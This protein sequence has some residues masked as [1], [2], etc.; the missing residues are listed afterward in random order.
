MLL[1]PTSVVGYLVRQ[2]QF[3]AVAPHLGIQMAALQEELAPAGFIW[4]KTFLFDESGSAVPFTRKEARTSQE[5]AVSQ[6]TS[7]SGKVVEDDGLIGTPIG[8]GM[9]GEVRLCELSGYP[10]PVAVKVGLVAGAVALVREAHVLS[11]MSGVRGFPTLHSYQAAGPKASGGTLIL[12]LLGP[13]L[14][15]VCSCSRGQRSLQSESMGQSLQL[16]TISGP[17]VLLVGRA[18]VRLLRPLHRAGFVHNDVK[19]ANILLG[20]GEAQLKRLSSV[21]LIDF[22]SCTR[23]PSHTAPLVS[24]EF[25]GWGASTRGHIGSLRFASV[26]ADARDEDTSMHPADDIESLVYTLAY[27]ATATLPWDGQPDALMTSTKRELLTNGT[28]AAALT[29]GV[30]CERTAAALRELYAEA[31]RCRGSAAG[32]NYQTCVAILEDETSD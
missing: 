22:G 14:K 31:R 19:P 29:D 26:A 24:D 1:L 32:V 10:K 5:R 8:M 3:T 7:D 28:M 30:K 9:H 27:L 23:V 13:S 21:H 20:A 4:G 18:L 17:M 11:I 6:H 2:P 16:T 25:N 12:E 15:D